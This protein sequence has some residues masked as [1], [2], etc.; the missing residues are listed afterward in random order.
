MVLEQ[1]MTAQTKIETFCKTNNLKY[2]NLFTLIL[3]TDQSLLSSIIENQH[4]DFDSLN[5][6]NINDIDNID[7]YDS[8]WVYEKDDYS[9]SLYLNGE[10][11]SNNISVSIKGY[12]GD[13]NL[14]F[15]KEI[16]ENITPKMLIEKYNLNKPIFS[17]ICINGLF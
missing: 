9:Y 14:V 6:T 15:S 8:E 7:E 12:D 13:N 1:I 3:E 4:M 17:D 2:P 11:N 16:K 5:A 10:Y